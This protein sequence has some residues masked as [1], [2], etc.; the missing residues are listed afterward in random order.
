M[1]LVYESASDTDVDMG[2]VVLKRLILDLDF[3]FEKLKLLDLFF[4]S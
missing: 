4:Q 3:C 2:A 1:R